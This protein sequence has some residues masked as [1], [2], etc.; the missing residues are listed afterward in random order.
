MNVGIDK[1]T[2]IFEVNIVRVV[3]RGSPWDEFC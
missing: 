2:I 1:V 3:Y